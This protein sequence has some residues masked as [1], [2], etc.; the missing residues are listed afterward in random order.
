MP[1]LSKALSKRLSV[2]ED[3]A[4]ERWMRRPEAGC[5]WAWTERFIAYSPKHATILDRVVGV[6]R[7]EM[8]AMVRETAPFITGQMVLRTLIPRSLFL[9][10]EEH[11]RKVVVTDEALELGALLLHYM[12]LKGKYEQATGD[13]C[14]DRFRDWRGG[15][16]NR[17]A[18]HV[19]VVT[20]ENDPDRLWFLNAPWCAS[21]LARIK[22]LEDEA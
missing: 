8:P 15:R 12:M 17:Y 3:S 7:V 19:P 5:E 6:A 18:R 1:M 11:H 10:R 4:H 16:A 2:V 22:A 21:L 9:S 20:R 13:T 14:P